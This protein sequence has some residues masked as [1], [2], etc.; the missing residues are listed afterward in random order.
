[1]N[2]RDLLAL[3]AK[4]LDA[5]DS[6]HTPGGKPVV[7]NEERAGR[8]DGLWFDI[9]TSLLE[10]LNEYEAATNDSWV[11]LGEFM[12]AMRDRHGVDEDDVRWVVNFLATPTR[13]TT[14][15]ADDHGVAAGESSTKSTA[16]VERPR[17]RA[18]DKCRLTR[19]GR[20]VV[21]LAKGA[22]GLLYSQY[23]AQKILLALNHG[24]FGAALDQ[25][26]AVNQEVRGFSQELTRL[27]EQPV[28]Q[29]T[30]DTYESQKEAYL[31]A[32]ASVD[33][34]AEQA[35]ALFGTESVRTAF[36]SWAEGMGVDAPSEA[37]FRDRLRDTVRSVQSLSGRVQNMITELV[38]ARREVVGNIDFTQAALKLVFSPP[39]HWE[40]S[41][42]LATLGPWSPAAAFPAAEDLLGSLPLQEV[43]D[44]VENLV[45]DDE[46]PDEDGVP[47]VIVEFL[48]THGEAIKQSLL[49]GEPVSLSSAIAKGMMDT[50][51]VDSLG[52]LVGVYVSPDWLQLDGMALRVGFVADQLD[53]DM[54]DG[55]KL[56]GDELVIEALPE[57]NA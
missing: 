42:A 25:A 27:L 51:G 1:M 46:V 23:D 34:T 54:P 43:C 15:T 20:T 21:K 45:F 47:G 39:A 49:S 9:A 7:V 12:A 8:A 37:A 22:Q 41:G 5:H 55:G 35:L 14:V 26:D 3:T 17:Y 24:D 33:A 36:E 10:Y 53:L 52:E 19:Q 6:G 11:R 44:D 4:L 30:R 38:A 48:A 29:E 16:L 13:L 50:G 31:Q 57:E 18:A 40:L 56:W 2:W 28:S 32:I